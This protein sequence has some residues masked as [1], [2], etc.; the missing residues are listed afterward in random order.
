[1]EG[2][3]G[4]ASASPPLEPS[5]R[6]TASAGRAPPRR[7]YPA[8]EAP[9]GTCLLCSFVVQSLSGV[10]LFATPWTTAHQASR[11]FTISRSLPRLMSIELVCLLLSFNSSL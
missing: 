8:A 11:S 10:R 2:S 3:Y 6:P 5:C 1:M 9:V 7:E 4:V